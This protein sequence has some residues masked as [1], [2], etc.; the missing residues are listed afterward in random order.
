[1]PHRVCPWW[2]GYFLASPVRAWVDPPDRLLVNHICE[3]MTVL[4]PGPGMGFY[5][6]ELARRAGADGRVIAVDIQPKMLASL[7]RR[8]R[9]AG[10]E[11]RIETRLA[12]AKSM[13]LDDLN[14]R[15]DFA[16]AASVVHEMPSDAVF[17]REAFE[18]LKPGGVL[19]LAEPS[20]HVTDEA[21]DIELANAAKAG[22]EMAERPEIRRYHTA[23][24]RKTS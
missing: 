7:Q 15:V 11:T 20:G 6:L 21:F 8:A 14:G 17:F 12:S 2:L 9:K 24:L 13:N 22:L 3:G 19:L 1:M 5:T 4:E 10:L 16:L 23:L 18:A